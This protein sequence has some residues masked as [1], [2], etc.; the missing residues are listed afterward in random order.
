MPC[1]R[2]AGLA[3]ALLLLLLVPAGCATS[4][5][6]FNARERSGEVQAGQR[7]VVTVPSSVDAAYAW[8]YRPQAEDG[9]TL[10]ETWYEPGEPGQGLWYFSYTAVRAGEARLHFICRRVTDPSAATLANYY[11]YLTVKP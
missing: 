9:V 8:E 3:V 10:R 7:F 2:R 1:R 6:M 11:F 4:L 5:R